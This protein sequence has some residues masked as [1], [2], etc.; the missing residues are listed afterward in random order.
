MEQVHSVQEYTTV[1]A[2]KETAELL[3]ALAC[4]ETEE[5]IC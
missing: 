2:L 3:T 5:K 4:P 1:Q